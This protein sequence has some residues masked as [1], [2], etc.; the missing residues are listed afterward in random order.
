M[1]G[2]R[3]GLGFIGGGF[4]TRFPLPSLVAVRPAAA[5]GIWSPNPAHARETA[6][7]ARTLEVG[8]VRPYRSIADMVRDPAIQAIW[9]CGP[10]HARSE[11]HTSEL[12]SHSF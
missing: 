4:I 9:I 10:N 11:E 2:D 7:Y 6:K 5:R 3:L 12:Q 1:A 8:D